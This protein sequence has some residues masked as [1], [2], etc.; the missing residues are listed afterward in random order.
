VAAA[1][2]PTPE[3]PED[4][5]YG[6][7]APGTAGGPR[8]SGYFV[9]EY[10][11]SQG[12][13]PVRNR[14]A[15]SIPAA[16]V[17]LDGA[18]SPVIHYL[19]EIDLAGA[20]NGLNNSQIIPILKDAYVDF[21]AMP[22]VHLRAGQMRKPAGF[23][24]QMH[25][26]DLLAVNRSLLTRVLDP[27]DNR[28]LGVMVEAQP[29]ESIPVDVAVGVFNGGNA[30]APGDGNQHKDVVGR[31]GWGGKDSAVHFGVSGAGGEAVAESPDDLFNVVTTAPEQY[32]YWRAGAD[33]EVEAA[34]FFFQGE[35]AYGKTTPKVG[36]A[37][38]LPSATAGIAG[39]YGMLGYRIAG[40]ATPFVRY[41][42]EDRT[43]ESKVFADP[44][45]WR[46]ETTAGVNLSMA[47]GK[48]IVRAQYTLFSGSLLLGAYPD[49]QERKL[50]GAFSA[51]AQ[52]NF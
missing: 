13:G 51:N 36:V 7:F 48:A 21:E 10:D 9:S 39:G 38:I 20:L 50:T 31:A 29:L 35:G 33:V 5:D 23:E 27:D 30:S 41:T 1:P 22:R 46:N 37:S 19:V 25:E 18:A 47:R 16:R 11:A 3:A 26:K 24:A 17:Q 2:S 44:H 15:F 49:V 12:A 42:Y 43:I 32:D 34:G 28:D 40:W 8:V 52:V 14:N 45:D 6:V 4:G